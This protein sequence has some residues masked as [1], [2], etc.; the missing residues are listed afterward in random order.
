MYILSYISKGEHE[1]G[2]LLRSAKEQL[3]EQNDNDDLRKQMK[4]LGFVYFENREVSVQEAV[5]RVCGMKLKSCTRDV[6]FIP[7]DNNSTRMSKPLS[8]IQQSA[9]AN[10]ESDDIWMPSNA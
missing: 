9:D 7:T 5:M 2:E 1:L 10:G 3:Q 4:K 8:Q 6:L